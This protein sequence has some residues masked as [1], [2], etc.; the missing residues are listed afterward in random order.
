MA[1]PNRVGVSGRY[2]ALLVVTGCYWATPS[3]Q[4]GDAQWALYY[5]YREVIEPLV[6]T[7]VSMFTYRSEFILM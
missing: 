2:W 5:L 3:G 1:L 4:W 7:H 6:S